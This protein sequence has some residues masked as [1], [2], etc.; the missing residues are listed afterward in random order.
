[1]QWRNGLSRIRAQRRANAAVVKEAALQLG[2]PSRLPVGDRAS[3]VSHFLP[4]F[5]YRLY[6]TRSIHLGTEKSWYHGNSFVWE[7]SSQTQSVLIC[8]SYTSHF[9]SY[10]VTVPRYRRYQTFASTIK[11][12][13]TQLLPG[14]STKQA[15]R[16]SIRYARVHASSMGRTAPRK[17]S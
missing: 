5:F 14:S 2:H 11:P 4:T 16:S 6:S 13:E 3:A 12:R 7:Y 8:V 15:R 17:P 1:V 10:H 9:A